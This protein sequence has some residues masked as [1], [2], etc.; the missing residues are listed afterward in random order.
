M[1]TL[2]ALTNMRVNA[3]R[4]DASDFV[5]T[6]ISCLRL[7]DHIAALSATIKRLETELEASK[8]AEAEAVKMANGT[9]AV[10]ALVCAGCGDTIPPHQTVLM[11]YGRAGFFH[12]NECAALS[13]TREAK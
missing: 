1:L 9:W 2:D 5:Q 4:A 11:F 7:L 8:D 10:K 3:E 12:S 13:E 6:R